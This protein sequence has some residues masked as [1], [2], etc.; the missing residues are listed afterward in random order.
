MKA[1]VTSF[2]SS[3]RFPTFVIAVVVGFEFGLLALLLLPSSAKFAEEFRTSCFGFDPKTGMVAWIVVFTTFM[4]PLIVALVVSISWW[5]E[6]GAALQTRR[7]AVAGYVGM[8]FAVALSIGATLAAVSGPAETGELPF[9]AE[10]LR[11]EFRP[12]EFELKDHTGRPVRIT[13]FRGSVVLVTAIFSRCGYSCPMI[14]GDLQDEIAALTPEQL[15]DLRIVVI[16]LDPENDTPEVLANVAAAR[17]FSSPPFH[18][19]TGDPATVERVLDD[20]AVQRS[21]DAKTGLIDHASLFILVDREGR[22]AYRF[23]LDERRQRW[24][25]SALRLLLGERKPEI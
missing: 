20:F 3:W 4:V 13:D 21:R 9:P 17:G 7:P 6:L 2:F 11:T 23:T 12:P 16:T 18:L 22:V 15:E 8:G 24:L 5:R 10:V 1:L 25:G 14:L 19:L